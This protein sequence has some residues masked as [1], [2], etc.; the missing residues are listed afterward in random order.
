MTPFVDSFVFGFANSLHCACMCGPLAL[1]LH[2]GTLAYH[3]ARLIGYGALGVALGALGARLGSSELAAPTAW[4][5]LVLAA[6]IVVL[7]SFGERGSIE[8]P[9]VGKLLQRGMRRAQA[10][11]P[12]RRAGLVG[13][14]TPLLPCGLLWSA[15]AGA[16]IAGSA[17]A[18]GQVMT[19]FALGS[20]PLLLLAQHQMLLLSRRFG[21]ALPWVQRGAMLLA[22]AVLV[23]RGIAVLQRG[24]CCG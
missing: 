8:I 18:G 19:G 23:W 24:S 16:T 13:L 11:P 9:L 12:M 5:A 1:S 6:G 14:L 21:R 20:L 2:G 17:F 22:A 4:V 10:M 7:V 3:G 15:F